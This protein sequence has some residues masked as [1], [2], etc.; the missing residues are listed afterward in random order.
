[1]MVRLEGM[2]TNVV[3]AGWF[4][5]VLNGLWRLAFGVWLLAFGVWRLAFGVWRLQGQ[6]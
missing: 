2:V 1:M 6:A 4:L 5:W 3:M